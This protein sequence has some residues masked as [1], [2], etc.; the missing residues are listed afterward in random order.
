MLLCVEISYNKR[1][2]APNRPGSVAVTAD[3]AFVTLTHNKDMTLARERSLQEIGR[4]KVHIPE[5]SVS[6]ATA[7]KL[8]EEANK[9]EPG[10]RQLCLAEA[11]TRTFL[12]FLI[13]K[14]P[15]YPE[16]EDLVWQQFLK[17]NDLQSEIEVLLNGEKSFAPIQQR[18]YSFTRGMF[19]KSGKT[20]QKFYS[21][22]IAES[23][24]V[25]GLST[26]GFGEAAVSFLGLAM[27]SM[28]PEHLLV[29]YSVELLIRAYAAAHPRSSP[30]S[31]E[32]LEKFYRHFEDAIPLSSKFEE[33]TRDDSLFM[34]NAVHWLLPPIDSL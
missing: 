11:A 28:H 34:Y 14:R 26:I 18:Y 24:I 9:L 7:G 33:Y 13:S 19:G 20:R 3:A 8:F 12:H 2:R 10:Q 30:L 15:L 27:E 17:S 25:V 29:F 22:M 4:M 32:E 6:R 16:F 21:D 5:K 23:G 31:N 1:Q